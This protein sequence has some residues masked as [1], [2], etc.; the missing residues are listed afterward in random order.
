M[1]N[2]LDQINFM[3]FSNST[4]KVSLKQIGI[5]TNSWKRKKYTRILP[6][7]VS[8]VAG[9]VAGVVGHWATERVIVAAFYSFICS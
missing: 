2:L 5:K 7:Q 9:S 1:G 6:D 3:I 8:T 4:G